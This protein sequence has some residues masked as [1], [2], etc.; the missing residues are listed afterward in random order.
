MSSMELQTLLKAIRAAPSRAELSLVQLREQLEAQ[1]KQA[2]PGPDIRCKPVDAG[3][4]PCE[5]VLAPE[6]DQRTVVLYLHGGGYYRGSLNTHRELCSRISRA[7]GAAVLNVGYRLAP[8]HPFPAALDDALAAW[9]WLMALGVPPGRV[10]AAGDSAG[11]GLAAAL[12]LVLRDRGEPLP[13]AAVLLSPWT[14]LEQTGPSMRTRAAADPSLTK[15]YLDRFATA[16]LNGADARDPRA[17]PLHG[18]LG[19]LP[20]LL[21]QVGT[22]E[23]LEDD[24]AR[25]ADKAR[26]AGGTVTLE[27]WPDMIH[28]WQ[29]FA[30]QL[31]EA[32]EATAKIGAFVKATLG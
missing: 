31:P 16:Y 10:V 1:A 28:V 7:A 5:W 2:P 4:V 23:I 27:R 8:E 15:A 21:I 18:D 17:S 9:R 22:A 14:D 3:G 19:G 29:R 25:F 24:A 12:M 26:A 30:A 32:R 11:G 13:G 6:A 20:P